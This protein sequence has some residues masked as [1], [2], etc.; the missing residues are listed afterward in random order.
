MTSKQRKRGPKRQD[1]DDLLAQALK[2][3]LTVDKG[4]IDND[5]FYPEL[6]DTSKPKYEGMMRLW[7]ADVINRAELRLLRETD[8]YRIPERISDRRSSH[9]ERHDAL[10]GIYWMRNKSKAR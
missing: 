7:E 3:G 6:A 2:D 1:P 5:P 4:E 10:C 9:N 8:R